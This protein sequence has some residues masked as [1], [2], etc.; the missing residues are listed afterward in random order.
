MTRLSKHGLPQDKPDVHRGGYRLG[1]IRR[2]ALRLL[3]PYLM[4]LTR[5]ASWLITDNEAGDPRNQSIAGYVLK[6][7][8]A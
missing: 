1:F 5:V 4:R 6:A 8:V 3:T 2:N 7:D